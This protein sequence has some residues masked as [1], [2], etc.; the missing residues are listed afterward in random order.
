MVLGRTDGGLPPRMPSGCHHRQMRAVVVPVVTLL[1]LTVT[2]C[3]STPSDT[4][5]ASA[6]NPQELL[7]QAQEHLSDAGTGRFTSRVT[8]AGQDLITERSVYDLRAEVFETN[9]I[10]T[11]VAAEPGDPTE[12]E[13]RFRFTG[14]GDSYMQMADWGPWD[15]CWLSYDTADF[16]EMG[17]QIDLE[18][19]GAGV[20]ATID[21][22]LHAELDSD[23]SADLADDEIA[24]TV[25]GVT[26]MQL[27]GINPAKLLAVEDFDMEKATAVRVPL[28]VRLEDGEFVTA[29][30]SGEAIRSALEAEKVGL[31]QY[32]AYLEQLLTAIDL[33]P[34]SGEVAI[35]RPGDSLIIPDGA[36]KDDT[37]PANR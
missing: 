36:T 24:L 4:S 21:A 30:A 27:L 17:V 3:G 16:G 26:G 14:D 5:A 1:L 22:L 7:E 18:G 8:V 37:C 34:E 10:I 33:E 20:P 29:T 12:F 2:G 28:D 13:V 19:P 32:D 9:R 23:R 35:E 15:G 25:P 11:N 6:P 31:G